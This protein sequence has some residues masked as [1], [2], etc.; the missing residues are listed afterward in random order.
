MREWIEQE[1][2]R[3]GFDAVG[4]ARAGRAA[5]ADA[6]LKWIGEGMHAGMGWME[7]EPER[8]CDPGLVQEGARSVVVVGLNGCQPQPYEGFHMATYA[9]GR[10]YHD[11]LLERLKRLDVRMRE[12]WGGSSRC[13]VDT[14][15]VLERGWA[16]AAG[17][18]WQGKSTMLVHPRQG[19]WLLLG[20]ILTTLEVEPSQPY[21]DRCGSCT[22]CVGACPTGAILP[23]YRVDAR[24]CL[25][26]YSIEHKGS[27]PEEFRVAMG[28]RVFGCDD[29]LEACPWNRWAVATREGAFAAGKLPPLR[30]MLGWTA[31][32][33]RAAFKGTPVFRL[34]LKRWL[35]N[36][37]VVLGNVGTA[38][39]LPA[40]EQACGH[41]E[42]LVAEHACWAV[43][44]MAGRIARSSMEKG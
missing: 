28:D 6:F 31:E 26:Y 21:P 8:R 43:E 41:P 39:D 1:A 27:I 18:G 11:V 38:E 20:V 30:K 3:L 7:R 24:R 16:Q 2:G 34:R 33:F 19:T 25:A 9:L 40:L 23:P 22:R 5:G 42:P 10:D 14:G 13:Y 32:D 44:R 35:R 29:C 17:L 12:R 4:V 37:C 36:V 15:P